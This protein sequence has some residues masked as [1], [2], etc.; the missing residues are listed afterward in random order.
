MDRNNVRSRTK[1]IYINT[2]DPVNGR[3][4]VCNDF[5]SESLGYASNLL[6]DSE[7]AIETVIWDTLIVE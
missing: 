1:R 4:L 7:S 2:F 5:T 3:S 6:T